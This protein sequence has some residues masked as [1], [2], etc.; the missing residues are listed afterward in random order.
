[1]INNL[2]FKFDTGQLAHKIDVKKIKKYLA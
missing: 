2:K 1:M